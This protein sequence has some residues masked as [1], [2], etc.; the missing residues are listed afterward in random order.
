VI[1]HR[2]LE[3]LRG[4][5]LVARTG[6]VRRI[7]P[8]AIEADGPSLPLGALCAVETL[9]SAGAAKSDPLLAEV[10]GVHPD[11]I[12]LTPLVGDA[13]TF[14]GAQVTAW[15]EPDRVPVGDAFLG[16]AVDALARPIDSGKVVR[17]E[18][19]AP[20]DCI[21]A[22]PLER[23]TPTRL[24]T[25]G[26]RTIDGLLTL[27]EGQ[28]VGVFAAS[29]V[30]KTS[31]MV[32]LAQQVRADRCVICLVGER[33]REVETLWSHQLS[34][35]ARAR[36]ALVAATSDQTAAMRV[37]S[38]KYALTL[39]EYW[40]AQG[41][42]VLL[43]MD[44]MTRLAMAMREIGLAA[45]EP[46]T[47]R[48]YT[49]GVFA[50]IPKL[51]ERCGALKGQGAISAIMTVL[52]ETD[53]VDDPIC[54]MMKALL[55]GHIILSRG[56]AEQGH[57]PAID[58]THSISRMATALRSHAHQSSAEEAVKL[59]SLYEGAKT[60]IE[61]GAYVP[62]S[63]PETDRAIERRGALMAFLRQRQGEPAAFE[64]TCDALA[65]AV[66]NRT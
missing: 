63:N 31:L 17:A 49:P 21:A 51:V 33:A 11:S 28:R 22:A 39:A 18:G 20:L 38:A 25:T 65:L 2:F 64:A 9:A 8:T 1:S 60:L 12:V 23:E 10:A 7:L 16:R 41:H 62:G 5:D 13:S 45:G 27:A 53:E 35:E 30:G 48:A 19:F 26:V 61:A 66:G 36:T 4:T 46:P 58:A 43:L 57:F 34:N 50:A 55:D 6:R 37:R 32:E 24:L 29:G 56:L 14:F 15:T 52:S 59:L 42:H 3:Q 40:R 44:S 54:E 47:I